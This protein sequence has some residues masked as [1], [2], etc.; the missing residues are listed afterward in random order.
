M[1]SVDKF[2]KFPEVSADLIRRLIVGSNT[3]DC[4]LDP[5]PSRFIKEYIDI[6]L[7][8]ITKL[9]NLSLTNRTFSSNWKEAILIPI[10]KKI[11]FEMVNKNYRPVSTYSLFL[12][13]LKKLLVWLRTTLGRAQPTS[14]LPICL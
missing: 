7:P 4:P 1:V 12:K 9:V 14:Q 3:T 5:F 6:L 2:E 8:L 13:L 11:S 10:L